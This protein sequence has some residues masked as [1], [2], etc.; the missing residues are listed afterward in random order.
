MLRPSSK[1]GSKKVLDKDSI[2]KPVVDDGVLAQLQRASIQDT[3]EL[4]CLSP[5]IRIGYVSPLNEY[6]KR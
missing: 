4:I 3:T 2:P 1:D 6:Y 5:D